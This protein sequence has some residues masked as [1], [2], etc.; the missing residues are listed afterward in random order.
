MEHRLSI[1]L[2]SKSIFIKILRPTTTGTSF[3][4]MSIKIMK[5]SDNFAKKDSTNKH[6]KSSHMETIT[7]QHLSTIKHS[8]T[9][10]PSIL[11][12]TKVMTILSNYCAIIKLMSTQSPNSTETA[13]TS[14]FSE[15]ISKL[16]KFSS[17]TTS[18]EMP[19]TM[20]E[21]QLSTSQPK[22]ATKISS[23]SFWI[24]KANYSEIKMDKPLST[25]AANNPS[26]KYSIKPVSNKI[27]NILK[28]ASSTKEKES[29]IK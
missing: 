16:P 2:H 23:P 15:V 3:G 24:K 22:M 6:N 7:T 29:A 28:W 18:M 5:N 13:Y 9:G 10:L 20:M 8:I 1:G 27:W 11:P 25:T 14:L 4:S 17:S 19:T 26:E 21:I 12:A